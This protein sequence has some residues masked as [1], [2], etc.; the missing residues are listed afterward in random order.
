M[1]TSIILTNNKFKED[2]SGVVLIKWYLSPIDRVVGVHKIKKGWETR[3]WR[4]IRVLITSAT[5]F[6]ALKNTL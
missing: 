4:N 3:L 6:P 5:W 1:A 2:I